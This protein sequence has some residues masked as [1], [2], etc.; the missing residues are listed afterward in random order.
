M[1]GGLTDILFG[2]GGSNDSG[3]A[4]LFDQL[5]V[6]TIEE[7]KLILQKYVE[8]GQLSPEQAE[9]ALVEANAY[10]GME[11]DTVGKQAQLSALQQLQEIGN[12][13]GLTA[14]DKAK[15]QAI[16]NEEQTASRGA[17]EAILQNAQARGA[18][19]SGLELMAQLKNQQEA[20]SRES[21]RD[22]NVAAMAQERALQALQAAGNQGSQLNQQQFGQQKA[23]ADSRNEIA[24]FNAANTQQVGLANTQANNQAQAANLQNKQ[25]VSNANVDTS[26]KQQQ[27][28]KGLSQQNFQNQMAVTQG[29]ANA[30]TQ[31]AQADAQK[32]AAD[33]SFM[34]T[35]AGAG[36]TTFAA[37]DERVKKDVEEF[38]A[39]DF[40]D[41]LT[42]YK[43]KYK[44]PGMGEGKQV[45]VMAQD[46]EKEVPQMV[47]D[48]PRGK[49]VDYSPSKA[50][51]P[52]LAGLADINERL[53]RLEG[54]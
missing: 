53:K 8:A 3:A 16:R 35:L 12:E 2:S 6:P 28:N 23:I 14:T 17:R 21:S 46:L 10:D 37:S 27:Y 22:L 54:K 40:L 4:K 33:M 48:T 34:G 7:Q 44:D 45:G 11:Q 18:G 26:N 41:S 36:A 29:K 15:L 24:K 1:F 19:G 5:K 42:G 50:G 43:Y 32:K 39:S 52:I 51:G 30:L 31:Q 25:N 9:A 38:N 49:M 20:A 47:E 13:G